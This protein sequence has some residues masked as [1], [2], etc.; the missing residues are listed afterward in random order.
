MTKIEENAKRTP[1]EALR[2]LV[3]KQRAYYSAWE[4]DWSRQLTARAREANKSTRD[5]S[6]VGEVKS[7]TGFSPA[8]R[9]DF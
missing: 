7:H 3:E 4:N 9:S 1:N 6:G 2:E 5:Q 8:S